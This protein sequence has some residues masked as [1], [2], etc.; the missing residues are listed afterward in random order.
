MCLERG[1]E[2]L[3][4]GTAFLVNGG[5]VTNSHVLRD[6]DF[7]IAVFRFEDMA[8][9]AGIRLDR[10]ACIAAIGHES[11]ANE[12]DVLALNLREPEFAGRHVFQFG[13]TTELRVG[14]EVGFMG[15][16]FQMEQLTC[17]VGYVSSVF[18]RGHVT[19]IQVDGSINGGNSGGPLIE[20]TRGHI[21]GIV[22]R[23]EAEIG[24]AH[25]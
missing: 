14:D 20:P 2:R 3:T 16:P 6:V 7:D 4:A 5:L 19:V 1:R 17:H 25:V 13:E 22:S 23:A 15:Y 12:H 24:R 18:Q 10:A 9:G 21:V 11:P 8:Y